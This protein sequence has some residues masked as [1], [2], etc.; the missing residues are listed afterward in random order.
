MSTKIS[1]VRKTPGF[2]LFIASIITNC[3]AD[4][5][6]FKIKIETMVQVQTKFS[7]NLDAKTIQVNI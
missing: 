3:L 6:P 5:L 4:S 1:L 2:F 7:E